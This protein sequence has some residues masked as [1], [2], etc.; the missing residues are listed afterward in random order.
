MFTGLILCS[1]PHLNA[2]RGL[3]YGEV[4]FSLQLLVERLKRSRYIKNLF[5]LTDRESEP[6]LSGLGE[7]VFV[8]ESDPYKRL[9]SFLE[10]QEITNFVRVGLESPLVDWEIID[11]L[12]ESHQS[13]AVPCSVPRGFPPGSCPMEVVNAT[14]LMRYEPFVTCPC[15]HHYQ[16]FLTNGAEI[17]APQDFRIPIST[18]M[19]GYQHA[20]PVLQQI[21]KLEPQ[22]REWTTGE[23]YEAITSLP[24]L[25]SFIEK[26]ILTGGNDGELLEEK[27]TCDYCG[28][29]LYPHLNAGEKTA[30]YPFL[31]TPPYDF[32]GKCPACGLVQLIRRPKNPAKLYNRFYIVSHAERELTEAQDLVYE[33]IF[34]LI[35]GNVLDVGGGAG[36]WSAFL[37]KSGGNFEPHMIDINSTE[38]E[39]A[40]RKGLQAFHG[41]FTSFNF[42]SRYQAITMF[43]LVEHLP[44]AQCKHFIRRADSLLEENGLLILSTPNVSSR[45]DA[46][47]IIPVPYHLYVFSASWLKSFV[48]TETHLHLETLLGVPMYTDFIVDYES[49]TLEP[50]PEYGNIG[51]DADLVLCFRKTS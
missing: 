49:N 33:R 3:S 5:I 39:L 29:E 7:S 26:Q 43:E 44:L 31:L 30:I 15:R 8:G 34:R 27:N 9:C 13:T 14:H 50:C 28:E 11:F 22:F 25:R 10:Q 19:N 42:N 20:Y 18:S 23:I 37:K 6:L 51:W 40:R 24:E 17:N 48:E 47:L 36:H 46:N 16:Q 32:F 2:T 38:V 12:L 41:D 21:V 35:S 1:L 4:I 45:Y